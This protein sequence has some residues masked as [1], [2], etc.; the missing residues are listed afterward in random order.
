MPI[1]RVFPNALDNQPLETFT[2][3]AGITFEVWLNANVPAYQ[4]LVNPPFTAHL[5][6]C[7]F[8]V[9]AWPSYCLLPNDCIDAIV[10]P[11]DPATWIYWIVTAISIGY[12]IYVQNQIPDNYNKTTPDG[13][14]I[15]SAN[16]QV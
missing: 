9:G 15:Y 10:S 16:L 4:P 13:S 3:N 1:I 5:N 12:S 11:K 7:E 14:S 8:P 6:G 2:A